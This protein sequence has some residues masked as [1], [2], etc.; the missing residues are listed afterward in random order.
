MKPHG[1]NTSATSAKRTDLGLS[2]VTGSYINGSEKKS[3][4]FALPYSG[5]PRWLQGEDIHISYAAG[6]ACSTQNVQM[7]AD[8]Q[9]IDGVS[10]ALRASAPHWGPFTPPDGAGHA[11]AYYERR[12]E[13]DLVRIR[14][15][16]KLTLVAS[17]G[18]WETASPGCTGVG[19]STV[20]CSIT[21]AP[22]AAIPEA[23][24]C[25][26]LDDCLEDP[27]GFTDPNGLPDSSDTAPE[28]PSGAPSNT[29]LFIVEESIPGIA[30]STD[31]PISFDNARSA[32][33][34]LVGAGLLGVAD[35]AD[36]FIPADCYGHAHRAQFK[37]PFVVAKGHA[38]CLMRKTL[39]EFQ[40][41]VAIKAGGVG[42]FSFYS[43]MSCGN[44]EIYAGKATPHQSHGPFCQSGDH[45][46]KTH[47]K[48]WISRG[49]NT[50]FGHG[51][52]AGRLRV[53][54]C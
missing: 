21:S 44:V 12:S 10:G 1:R 31:F 53:K 5:S 9:V 42:F 22:F 49:S 32:N 52:Q 7:E 4:C 37:N 19:T 33:S 14:A 6:V 46:Y 34:P 48:V 15:I 38:R 3:A 30:S 47:Y 51:Y 45:K 27:A 2:V 43:D 28:D 11:G 40:T 35:D 26:S 36:Q 50:G 17:G 29:G 18:R 25:P 39:F 41:C 8:A 23:A 20:I 16:L 24:E 13:T 54:S